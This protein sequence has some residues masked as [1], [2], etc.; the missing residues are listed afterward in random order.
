[1]VRRFVFPLPM[2]GIST[3]RSIQNPRLYR[4][5]RR[6]GYSKEEAARIAN[7][8]TP[9]HT[10]KAA[11][12]RAMRATTRDA[13]ESAWL[14]QEDALDGF[15]G[16]TKRA[17]SG[18]AGRHYARDARGRFAR[19]AGAAA[20]SD[21]RSALVGAHAGQRS[22]L[23]Q[24]HAEERAAAGRGAGL[25]EVR[26]RH[27][28]ERATLRAT[29]AEQRAALSARHA[30]DRA[31]EAAAAVAGPAKGRD[32][33]PTRAY[34]ADPNTSYTMRHRLVDMSEIQ[35]SNTANGAINPHYDPALQPRDRSRQASQAQ[36][37]AVARKLNPDVLV[38]D[39]HRIDGGSPIIDHN[40]NVLS[41][42]GRTLAL[43]RAAELHPAQY[44]AYRQRLKEEA[45][46][47]GINPAE[48]DG[49][50]HPV[51][52]RELTGDH[53]TAAFAREANSSGTLRMSPL[54]QAKVDAGQISDQHM[55]SFHVKEEQNIDQALRD[56][57]NRRWVNDFLKDI[58][59]NERATLL[60][61]NGELNQM[62][63]YRAKAAIYTRAFP[64]EHG[65]RL[66]ESMLESLDPDLKSIQTGIS[67]AL[68]ALSRARALTSSG[69]RDRDLDLTEDIARSVDVLARIK[70]N[71]AL[72][73]NTPA[74]QVVHKYLNQ[75][76][77]FDRELD[78]NQER[79]L[80]HLD[81]ISRR[82]AEV[83]SFLARYADIVER[84][85]PPGQA[86]LFGGGGRMTRA[87]LLDALLGPAEPATRQEGL[88]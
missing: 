52:V 67:G 84:Q 7:A 75:G 62:G 49:M 76:Q 70:D 31:T 10:V 79:L 66:A 85:P 61:R 71:P 20:R 14:V 27:A 39:F 33:E 1:M 18:G 15:G 40:G 23:R 36:I 43:Q 9:G 42:N 78:H 58:P 46:K 17:P 54:E 77:M 65:E 45:A 28:G 30:S 63:L 53:D 25:V 5:L 22:A 87:Q 44:E 16:A 73:A 37:D 64:G 6:R 51:L 82:P 26:Q 35:A 29:H 50:R 68:P 72:T 59:D 8:A 86:D 80:V 57:D 88:F 13:N 2:P 32:G 74:N 38:T 19:T 83:R 4:L 34:G 3:Y 55:L 56:K 41:G 60:T 48:I 21:E 12:P 81:K 24:R 47:L 11:T 69:E